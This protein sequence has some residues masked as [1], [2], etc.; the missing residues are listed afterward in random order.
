MY[1]LSG[2]LPSHGDFFLVYISSP[3]FDS[4]TMH[5]LHDLIETLFPEAPC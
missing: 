1:R 3:Y 4:G 2:G 5:P